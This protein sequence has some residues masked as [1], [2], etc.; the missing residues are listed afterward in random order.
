MRCKLGAPAASPLAPARYR[1]HLKK[2]HARIMWP[3]ALSSHL[4]D[5]SDAPAG[6]Q[7]PMG[8]LDANLI[9]GRPPSACLSSLTMINIRPLPLDSLPPFVCVASVKCNHSCNRN[10]HQARS[11]LALGPLLEFYQRAH[12]GSN[13]RGANE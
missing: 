13:P 8:V 1:C 10:L 2:N 7:I 6:M 12:Q 4:I 11:N 3:V 9:V 5:A